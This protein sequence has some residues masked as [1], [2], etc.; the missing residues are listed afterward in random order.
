MSP[1]NIGVEHGAWGEDRAVERLRQ[2]GLEIIDRNV[3]PYRDRRL[4]ID[5]IAYDRTLDAMVFV[6]VKQH[7]RHSS[8][9]SRLRSVDRRKMRN[10]RL[11]C[12]A[13]RRRNRW[14]GSY[15]F[16]VIEIFGVPGD[17]HPEIDH[18]RRVNLFVP[19]E[20]FVRW[21]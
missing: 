13:W 17:R 14:Q 4:E 8:A 21:D 9:E 10:L 11:A 16:D 2:E 7:A 15:R 5:I 12:N 20:R 6:E 3:R 19:S 18:I 1:R